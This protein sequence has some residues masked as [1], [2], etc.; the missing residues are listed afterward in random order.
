MNNHP[1]G[2]HRLAE[3]EEARRQLAD[4]LHEAG[5][6]L[7]TLRVDPCSFADQPPRPLVD[8]G[9]CTPTVARALA[10]AVQRGGRS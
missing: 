6:P 2:R 8:L 9:R 4:A 10:A 7:P 3:A 5:V 1:A